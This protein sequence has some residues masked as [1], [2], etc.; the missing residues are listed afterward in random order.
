VERYNCLVDYYERNRDAREERLAQSDEGL[1][2][3][4]EQ[5]FGR[6]DDFS[7]EAGHWVTTNDSLDR[8]LTNVEHGLHHQQRNSP[9]ND[10]YDIARP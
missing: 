2:Q 7:R 8:A 3:S 9:M 6:H 4:Q 10:Q 1:H 5:L